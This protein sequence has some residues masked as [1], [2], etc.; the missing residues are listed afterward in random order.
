KQKAAKVLSATHVLDGSVR[1]MGERV[2]VATQLSDAETGFVL[3][4]ERYD[5]ELADAVA[6]Q[7][8]V[9]GQVATALTLALSEA[10]RTPGPKLTAVAFDSYLKAREHIKSGSPPRVESAAEM[11]DTVVRESPGFARAWSALAAARLEILRLARSDRARLLEDARE[12]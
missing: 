1:R 11:L 4:S 6:L 12:A 9:A 5:R 3:W 2:R 7:E 8:E 10:R